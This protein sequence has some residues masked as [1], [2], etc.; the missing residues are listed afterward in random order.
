VVATV[1][2]GGIVEDE[3]L[4]VGEFG[5]P[6][7]IER[8]R[9]ASADGVEH[10]VDG[11][12]DRTAVGEIHLTFDDGPTGTTE[13]VLEVLDRYDAT[14]VFFPIGEQV[15]DHAA[16]LRRAVDDGHRLGNHTWSH[17]R[18]VGMSPSEHDAAV[19]RT[20]IAIERATGITPS[21]LR[22]PGGALDEESRAR[23]ASAGLSIQLWTIDPADW[24]SPG[25]DVIVERVVDAASD[26]AIVLLHDGGGDRSQT[27]DALDDLLLQL[28]SA[29]YRF[30]ALPGC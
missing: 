16:V 20:Q 11:L 15:E 8:L 22:P 26:G 5:G 4:R 29:G 17:D 18:L 10:A 3:Q 25:A 19:G 12:R 9:T 27:L 1:R 30:T 21:C 13:K 2:L 23:A 24:T 28:S 14:A 7:T 6:L